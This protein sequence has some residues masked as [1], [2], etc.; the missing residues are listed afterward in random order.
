MSAS[1][2]FEDLLGVKGAAAK[3]GALK[4]STGG[5]ASS[6]SRLGVPKKVTAQHLSDGKPLQLE[7]QVLSY[8]QGGKNR[9]IVRLQL[10][11]PVNA[12]F[13]ALVALREGKAGEGSAAAKAALVEETPPA[14]T[15]RAPSVTD[16]E[17]S[18]P[19]K[20][21]GRHAES[22]NRISDWVREVRETS[23][24]PGSPGA[25]PRRMPS[26]A[27]PPDDEPPQWRGM[28]RASHAPPGDYDADEASAY[29]SVKPRRG[30][31]ADGGGGK[32]QDGYGGP[33]GK[34][35]GSPG[36][37][38]EVYY[39][40]GRA[41]GA[42]G[43]FIVGPGSAGS[44]AESGS[45]GGSEAG[46]SETGGPSASEAGDVHDGN[47]E[48]VVDARRAKRLRKLNRMVQSSAAQLASS[49]WRKHTVYLLGTLLIA[50][51]VCFVVLTAQ[52]DK[53]YNNANAVADLA[54]GIDKFQAIT[55]RCNFLQKCYRSMFSDYFACMPERM[56]F[57]RQK[58]ADNINLAQHTHQALY[59]GKGALQPF[60]DQRL[61]DYWTYKK[62]PE[63]I[64]YPVVV[65]TS[66]GMVQYNVS[67]VNPHGRSL[68][69]MGNVLVENAK[70]V[71][72]NSDTWKSD[73]N[74]TTSWQYQFQNGPASVFT[75]YSW[76]LDTF[77]DFAWLDLSRLSTVLIVLLV[78]EAVVVQ[79]S[80][81][82][83]QF[84]LL[85]R[86]NVSHMRLFS[87]FLALP[88]ATV[89]LMAQRHMQVDDDSKE[90][91]DDEELELADATAGATG[92]AS[93][94]AVAEIGAEKE[95]DK[96]KSVRMDV[97]DEEEGED[98]ERPGRKGINK[99]GH[100]SGK[101]KGK[102]KS[103]SDNKKKK[104]QLT[105]WPLFK[106]T[107]HKKLLGWLDP[108]FKRN[109]KKLLPSTSI[110]WRFMIPL[111]LWVSA[112]VVIYGISYN[113][114]Q[115]LQGPLA[116]LDT[117]AHV[118]YR[119]TRCRLMSNMLAFSDSDAANDHYRALLNQE[120]VDLRY[121]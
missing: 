120:L 91:V 87:V 77:V 48:L 75:G 53:R 93:Q 80:C 20:G 59:L 98:E 9:M 36:S 41:K 22:N 12:S 66:D 38:D 57:Y 73:M 117:S 16:S 60:A 114:L 14:V 68:W 89:R 34:Q 26:G 76:S 79:L 106:K 110:I 55:L 28:G 95:K 49:R 39:D 69:E 7:M 8:E 119:I 44:V 33:K 19:D 24:L 37:D 102:S 58:L 61:L 2:T 11:E 17:D 4:S 29:L 90:E 21:G 113:D 100:S 72:F 105:G 31:S 88:S 109:G 30:P 96:K 1:T 27:G 54:K 6:T 112:V 108:Q 43:G 18:G 42:R 83:Y 86:C 92:E 111:L 64:F 50:H 71:L 35:Y 121:E 115:G 52:V 10:V 85:Q 51:I 82:A 74:G 107:L 67:Q 70:T 104:P 81:M 94:A 97:A 40:G 25:S 56:A 13:P 23:Q 118:L 45:G 103:G 15:Q 47:E 84:Y 99:E 116:S 62:L 5:A 65:N 46:Q 3:K 32:W 63:T 78:V 101:G